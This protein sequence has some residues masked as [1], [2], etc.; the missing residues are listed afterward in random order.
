M[1]IHLCGLPG[2]NGRA[3]HLPARPCSGW[4]LPSRRRHRRRWC[5][6]TA[7][8]HHHLWHA[9]HAHRLSLSVA[10]VRQVTPTWLSPAPCPMESR[11]S[12]TNRSSPRPSGHLTI[13]RMILRQ[14]VTIEAPQNDWARRS[15]VAGFQ[16]VV[17]ETVVRRSLQ[18]VAGAN[19]VRVTRAELDFDLCGLR[20][21]RADREL[22]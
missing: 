22:T 5:A 10:L 6:L 9:R 11:L 2:R 4:G 17:N 1:A 13:A 7:P 15:A 20:K 3:A 21:C 8:F 12:S 14:C 19:V 18:E 16:F